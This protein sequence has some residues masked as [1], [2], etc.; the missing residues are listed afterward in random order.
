MDH[1]CLSVGGVSHAFVDDHAAVSFR[2]FFFFFS[3]TQPT[4]TK[5]CFDDDMTFL[6]MG[7]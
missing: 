6:P 3:F 7:V 5:P 1:V 4:T 2:V